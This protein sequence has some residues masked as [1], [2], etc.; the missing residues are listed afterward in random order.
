MAS[1]VVDTNVAVVANQNT[2]QATPG[3]ALI[4]VEEL[5]R[6][7]RERCVALDD[8]GL[9]LEEYRRHLRPSGQP[10][11]GDSF[12]KWL[13]DNQGNRKH[14]VAVPITPSH[15]EWLFEEFPQDPDLSRFDRGD[16][17]YV[18]VAMVCEDRPPILNASDSDW[19]YFREALARHGV[20]VTFLCPKLMPAGRGRRRRS[21]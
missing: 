9:I 17:K 21:R 6:I 5:I 13:W 18:A 12:F 3:D 19:W 1:V 7:R 10:G 4:C 2:P 14:V 15:D 16:R 11:P 20:Q 8:R